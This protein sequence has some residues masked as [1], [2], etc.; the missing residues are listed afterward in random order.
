M[1]FQDHHLLMD[2]TVFDNVAIPLIIAGA[3]GDDIRR[4]VSA[5]LDKS[6]AA[7]QSE[8]LPD[9]ALRR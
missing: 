5:A 6:R 4:R 1:I 3:S 9:P 8:K 2:R 7:R